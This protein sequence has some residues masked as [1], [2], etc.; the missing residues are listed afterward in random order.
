[1]TSRLISKLDEWFAIDL[2]SL[3]AFRIALAGVF[4]FDL[5]GRARDLRAHYTEAGVLP[6]AALEQVAGSGTQFSLHYHLS[7]FEWAI[8]A[9]LPTRTGCV[10][11]LGRGCFSRS[12]WCTGSPD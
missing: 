3:A 7:P 9:L 2:R 11:F 4:L 6:V 8:A 1:M 12:V 10:R 5:A